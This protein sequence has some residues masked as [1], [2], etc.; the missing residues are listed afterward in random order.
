MID[1]RRFILERE[2]EML[3]VLV[4]YL[5]LADASS[6]VKAES[7]RTFMRSRFPD[8]FGSFTFGEFVILLQILSHTIKIFG[9]Q[10]NDGRLLVSGLAWRKVPLRCD[11]VS[12]LSMDTLLTRLRNDR[13]VPGKVGK[14]RYFTIPELLACNGGPLPLKKSAVYNAVKTGQLRSL[15]YGGKIL[16]PE[17]ALN[18]FIAVAG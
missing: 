14:T 18:A 15:R 10:D 6:F 5:E 12:Q 7:V 16:V 4:C 9:G 3:R 17:D 1:G 8:V 2:V 13:V 11:E